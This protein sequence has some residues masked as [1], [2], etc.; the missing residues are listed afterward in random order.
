MRISILSLSV[1]AAGFFVQSAHAGVSAYVGTAGE[2]L[3]IETGSAMGAKKALIKME[4]FESK[5]SGKVIAVDKNDT[6][7]SFKY[8]LELSSGVQKKT[9]QIIVPAGSDLIKGSRVDRIEVYLQE[10][11]TKPTV[12]T[13]D[14]NLTASSQNINLAAESKKSPFKPEVD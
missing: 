4:G 2:K 1:I 10:A 11:P 8:D 12:L 5:W 3:F 9:W 7:Y 14:A 13:H 6:R